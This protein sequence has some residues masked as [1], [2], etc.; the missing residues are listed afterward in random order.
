MKSDRDTWGRILVVFA[1]LVA[2]VQIT[3]RA[4]QHG[5]S[6]M[7]VTV[8]VLAVGIAILGAMVWTPAARW[9][10]VLG[11]LLALLV[12]PF[13]LSAGFLVFPIAIGLA[14]ALLLARFGSRPSA[15]PA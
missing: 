4:W 11:T 10:Y 7:P 3:V 14:G 5:L 1:L 13:G 8:A 6:T 2:A 15:A 9:T 12:L